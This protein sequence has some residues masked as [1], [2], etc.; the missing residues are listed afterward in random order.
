MKKFQSL[1][2]AIKLGIAHNRG[3][4][5]RYRE[6]R[7]ANSPEVWRA[8]AAL[9]P[10][11]DARSHYLA[12]AY[13]RGVPYRAVEYTTREDNGPNT[14]AIDRIAR[15]YT[16]AAEQGSVTYS[17]PLVNAWLDEPPTAAM[18]AAREQAVAAWRAR[19][20]ARSATSRAQPAVAP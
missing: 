16:G 12:L 6:A 19:R 4:D 1:R 18:T 11:F 20:T 10:R 5:V 13:L 8:F 17:N 9:A 15:Q 3:L 14:Y 7:V 2:D